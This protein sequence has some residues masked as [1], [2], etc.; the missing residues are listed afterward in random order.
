M[1]CAPR[2]FLG[3]A[4]GSIAGLSIL[5]SGCGTSRTVINAEIAA[6]LAK[7]DSNIVIVEVVNQ[8]TNDIQV[9]FTID[10]LPQTV[11]CTTLQQV[12]P[13]TLP[14]CPA[15]V[16]AVEQ[17]SLDAQGRF[18]GGRLFNGNEAFS[19]TSGEFNCESVLIYKFTESGASAF[20]I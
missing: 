9:D 12:C 17:R 14:A 4:V 6:A 15:E 20:A 13:V 11:T 8:T 1:H 5:T 19:F 3:L 16:R 18:V 10:G 7:V 2:L